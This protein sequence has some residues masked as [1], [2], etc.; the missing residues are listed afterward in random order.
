MEERTYLFHPSDK[1]ASSPQRRAISDNNSNTPAC[2]C[3][4]EKDFG[5]MG[6]SMYPESRSI[7]NVS[8]DT[9]PYRAEGEHQQKN[10]GDAA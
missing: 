8:S 9:P 7:S 10:A 6:F 5:A 1:R 3:R 2:A 4:R